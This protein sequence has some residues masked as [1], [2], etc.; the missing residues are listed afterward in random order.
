MSYYAPTEDEAHAHL[1]ADT[2]ARIHSGIP[3]HSVR[4]CVVAELRT[5]GWT[6]ERIGRCFGVTRERI[7]GIALQFPEQQPCAV[8]GQLVWVLRATGATVRHQ[9]DHVVCTGS[10]QPPS[11]AAA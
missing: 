2:C 5:Q 6:Y 11:K 9:A 1:L 4:H 10:G 8:C 3:N 7:R